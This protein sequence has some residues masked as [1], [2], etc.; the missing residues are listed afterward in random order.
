MTKI[1]LEIPER[2][3]DIGNFAVGR[4]LPF[5]SKRMVGPFIFIDHIG[6]AILGPDKDLDVAPHPHIGLATLTYLLDGS[7]IHR[8]SLGTEIEIKPGE[9][10]WMTAGKGVVHSERTPEYL[11]GKEKR[12]HG[13]Q[14]WIALPKDLEEMEP[15]FYH[16]EIDE[17]PVWERDGA[18]FTLIAGNA[19]GKSSSVPVYSS[20]FLLRV[21]SAIGA[22]I[23]LTG[24]V[25]GEVAVYILDGNVTVEDQTY[26]PGRALV[27]D[28]TGDISFE[29][30]AGS[31]VFVFGG[32]PFPEERRIYWNFV[33]SEI[34]RLEKASEM[35]KNREFPEVPGDDGYVPLPKP[36]F[37]IKR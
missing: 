10:N 13:L 29:L 20:L 4:I 18:Q 3:A 16:A 25:K 9:V 7:I 22:K 6:P 36:G 17:L 21:N 1:K 26:E 32:V 19:M 24:S 33:S 12:V 35:W 8:D 37:R 5:R 15:D 11:R 30:A 34:E 27:F 14:I 2:P 31:D 28:E 23:D